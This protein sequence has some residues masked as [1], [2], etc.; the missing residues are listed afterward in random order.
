MEQS[1][2]LVSSIKLTVRTLIERRKELSKEL[3]YYDS[4]INDLEHYLEFYT[5]DAIKL[6][7]IG[8]K[9][10]ELRIKRRIVKKEKEFLEGF[11][12]K[13]KLYDI[14]TKKKKSKKYSFKTDIVSIL[15]LPN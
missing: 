11:L 14:E 6:V 8:K 7:K 4:A 9:I 1:V 10:K 15:D 3:S 13:H 12:T 5:T 2:E